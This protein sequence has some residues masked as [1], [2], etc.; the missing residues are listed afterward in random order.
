MFSTL[1]STI[2]LT[3]ITTA[4]A[5]IVPR[6][7]VRSDNF[8]I[9]A[10]STSTNQSVGDLSLHTCNSTAQ[11]LPIFTRSN[12]SPLVAHTTY[13]PFPSYSSLLFPEL[14]AGLRVLAVLP[15][16]PLRQA[17]IVAENLGPSYGWVVD[18][19]ERELR[20]V[21]AG[22]GLATVFLSCAQKGTAGEYEALFL[23]SRDAE[24]PGGCEVVKLGVQFV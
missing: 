5:R 22:Q 4:Q 17:T 14:H 13:Q 10:Y 12:T 24:V 19:G 7:N 1:L 3:L 21:V 16:E 11:R 6:Q 15:D 23:G 9:T 2:V 8:T 18:E 20:H